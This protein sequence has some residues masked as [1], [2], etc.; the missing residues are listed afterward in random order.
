LRNQ[1][2]KPDGSGNFPELRDRL[3]YVPGTP[4]AAG[5]LGSQDV[6]AISRGTHCHARQPIA[7]LLQLQHYPGML[8]R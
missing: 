7:E 5:L 6:P 8:V 2:G 4:L 1:Q 3:A